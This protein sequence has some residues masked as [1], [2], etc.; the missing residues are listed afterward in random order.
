MKAAVLHAN[1]DL[2]WEEYPTPE[3]TENQ[4]LIRIKVTGIC[5]S[6]IPRVLKNGAH[7][8]PIVLGHEFSGEVVKTG[9]LTTGFNIGDRVTAAPLVPCRYCP[10]CLA[11]NFSLCKNYTFIGSRIQGSFAEYLA[12]PAV[13]AV[14]F[15][16]RVSFEQAAFFEPSTVA[17]HGIFC[18]NYKAGGNV[19]ILGGGTIGMFTL[20]WC[21]ILGAKSVTVFDIND[22]RLSL[23][24]E[25]GASQVI[26]TLGQDYL[27]KAKEQTRNRGY[28]YI[29]ETAGK[30]E[31]MKTAF[32]LAANKA[33]VCFIGTPSTTLSFTPK[34]FENLNRKEFNLTGSWMS[35]SSPFPGKEW[36]MTSQYLSSGVLKVTPSFI[37]KKFPLS[38]A[39]E[40]F[41]LFKDA[42]SVKGKVL[43]VNE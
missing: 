39:Q 35:Y 41:M 31:T 10:D 38:K 34:E 37:F 32:E 20:Q 42:K 6:D 22:S 28:D 25:L 21:N 17:L 43:L 12:V 26:N 30:T 24:L 36:M 27:E 3:I 7:S 33:K 23:A 13:N 16:D 5:G 14:K 19:A 8:Y 4:L 15:N 11:G 29:F 2:R 40:A 1:E 9:R 18:N